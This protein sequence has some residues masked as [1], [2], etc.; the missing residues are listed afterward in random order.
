M[1]QRAGYNIIRLINKP[2]IATA[3]V[4]LVVLYRYSGTTVHAIQTL[5]NGRG[6]NLFTYAKGNKAKFI[7]APSETISQVRPL[8]C[9][10]KQA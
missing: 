3:E 10:Y 2:D 6:N 9:S 5:S 1:L 8:R 4:L 7:R